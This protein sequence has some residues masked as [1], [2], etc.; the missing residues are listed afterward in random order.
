ML[1][2]ATMEPDGRFDN[3]LMSV[4]QACGGI[5]PLLHEFFSF[6]HRRTDFYVV[7]PSPRRPMGFAEGDA[8]TLVRSCGAGVC[9]NDATCD[10]VVVLLLLL[11]TVVAAAEVIPA[12]SVQARTCSPVVAWTGRRAVESGVRQTGSIQAG[13]EGIASLARRG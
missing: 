13:S 11:L 3:V 1:Q 5:G 10:V 6:L 2:S 4:T 7:D 8:K 9:S 12:V